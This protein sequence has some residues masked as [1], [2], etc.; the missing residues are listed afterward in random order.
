MPA[1]PSQLELLAYSHR[2]Q[3]WGLKTTLANV[4]YQALKT[5]AIAEKRV[6]DIANV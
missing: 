5:D 2:P 1:P 6:A 4:Y 3:F